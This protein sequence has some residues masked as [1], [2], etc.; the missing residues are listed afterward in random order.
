MCSEAWGNAMSEF[1]E[2]QGMRILSVSGEAGK[3]EAEN[4]KE[5]LAMEKKLKAMEDQLNQ[6]RN[7]AKKALAE[8][9]RR[10][11]AGETLSEQDMANLLADE[12][13]MEQKTMSMEEELTRKKKLTDQIIQ[14]QMKRTRETKVSVPIIAKAVYTY[15]LFFILSTSCLCVCSKSKQSSLASCLS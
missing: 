7:N 5:R 2:K 11:Q 1:Q 3:L 8:Q 12:K 4:M 6:Q 10:M 9:Q 15:E 14:E 13:Q